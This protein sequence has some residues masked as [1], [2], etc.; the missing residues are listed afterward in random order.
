MVYW[1]RSMI[2]SSRRSSILGVNAKNV[3]KTSTLVWHLVAINQFGRFVWR[4]HFHHVMRNM[5]VMWVMWMM[6]LMMGQMWIVMRNRCDNGK[7]RMFS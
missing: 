6:R 1:L 4:M 2:G 7:S 5:R 3:L